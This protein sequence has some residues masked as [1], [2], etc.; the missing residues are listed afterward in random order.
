VLA[1]VLAPPVAA[2]RSAWELYLPTLSLSLLLVAFVTRLGL[3]RSILPRLLGRSWRSGDLAWAL[4]FAALLLSVDHALMTRLGLAESAASHALLPRS[5][6]EK[7]AWL[8]VALSVGVSEELV[9]RGYLQ[10][11]I[12]AL[13]NSWL[14]GV[15]LQALLF[16][17][18]HAE[19][20]GS[21]VARFALYAFG[22]GCLARVRGSLW[23]AML[24]HVGL[25]AYA[26]LRG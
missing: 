22:F 18:A 23:A 13:T 16:A 14:A 20:G 1:L 25:D 3:G 5:A 12:A 19:Q 10:T 21:S 8:F 11:Q 4:G 26:G 15:L 24:A 17:I 9:Y 7:A 6:L 2:T